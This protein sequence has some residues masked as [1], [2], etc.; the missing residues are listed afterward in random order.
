MTLLP[1]SGT[2]LTSL[3]STST[4]THQFSPSMTTTSQKPLSP[5]LRIRRRRLTRSESVTR[6]SHAPTFSR[7]GSHA[8]APRW[9]RYS[10]NKVCPPTNARGPRVLLHRRRRAARFLAARLISLSSRAITGGTGFV[11][12][13]QMLPPLSSTARLRDTVSSVESKPKFFKNSIEF[14][15]M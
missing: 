8:H 7:V 11:C 6:C 12:A 4:T 13:A 9:T 5:T 3:T 1:P 14:L 2:S 15:F 10:R